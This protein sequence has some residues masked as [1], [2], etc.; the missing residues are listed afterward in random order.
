[1]WRDEGKSHQVLVRN[2]WDL[3]DEGGPGLRESSVGDRKEE[4]GEGGYS[5]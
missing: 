3:E 1:M 5:M 2:R 4:S